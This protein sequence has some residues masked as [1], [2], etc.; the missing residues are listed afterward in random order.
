[1]PSQMTGYFAT[2]S[3]TEDVL[4]HEVANRGAAQVG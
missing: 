4:M 2:F 3:G 1:M